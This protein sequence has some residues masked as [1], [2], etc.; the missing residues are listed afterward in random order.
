LAPRGRIGQRGLHSHRNA[1]LGLPCGARHRSLGIVS[2][3]ARGRD[4][5]AC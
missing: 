3:G 1:A 2:R 5:R 4:A